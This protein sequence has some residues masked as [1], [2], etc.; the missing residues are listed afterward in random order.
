MAIITRRITNNLNY[1]FT[2]PCPGEIGV[3]NANLIIPAS[4]VDLDLLTLCTDDTLWA[5]Q[6]ALFNLQRAGAI[7]VTGT[8]DTA[9]LDYEGVSTIQADSN[10]PL[11]DAVTLVS[12]SHI[13]MLQQYV[14]MHMLA[15]H[16]MILVQ[17]V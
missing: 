3:Q 16:G 11:N 2:L 8:V 13:H 1:T 4:A 15:L 14:Q 17:I 5:L 9:D 10:P 6:T 12:G 7:T